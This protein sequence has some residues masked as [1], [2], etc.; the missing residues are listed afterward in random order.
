MQKPRLDGCML[1]IV[2]ANEKD[3]GRRIVM[4][5]NVP[6]Y[7][8]INLSIKEEAAYSNVGENTIRRLLA[9]RGCPF[10]LKIGNRQLVKRKEFENFLEARHFL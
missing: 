4:E 1:L 8:K 6:V 7:N 9:E 5:I 3:T 10:L 2:E